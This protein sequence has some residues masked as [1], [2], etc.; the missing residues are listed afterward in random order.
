M[1]LRHPLF[2][3]VGSNLTLLFALYLGD[4]FDFQHWARFT[5]QIAAVVLAMLVF[6][7]PLEHVG[8]LP[9]GAVSNGVRRDLGLSYG[10]A[11][12][13][14]AC[15]IVF[16]LVVTRTP[17]ELIP[18]LF[19]AVVYVFL[20][21]M[22]ITSFSGA[23]NRLSFRAWKWL[24]RTGLALLVLV[25]IV[26]LIG[27]IPEHGLFSTSALLGALLFSG[28]LFKLWLYVRGRLIS[29]PFNA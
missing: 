14:H 26:T 22:V 23:K 3:V 4:A 7:G 6:L 9:S 11:M 20:F 28:S 27:A 24:H 19:G 13:I 18:A 5:A 17:L 8:L 29:E 10:L 2:F 1:L 21:A 25:S 12:A 15:A 16:F